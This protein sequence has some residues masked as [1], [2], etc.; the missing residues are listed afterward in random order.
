M[1]KESNYRLINIA[2]AGEQSTGRLS[3]MTRLSENK[4]V[5]PYDNDRKFMVAVRHTFKSEHF[6]INLHLFKRYDRFR[7]RIYSFSKFLRK[8]SAAIVIYDIT[9]RDSFLNIVKLI[10]ETKIDENPGSE[11][12][13]VYFILGNKSDLTKYREVSI[14]E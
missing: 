13:L 5:E 4:F 3:L 8:I 11:N 14:E 10:N 1:N 9:E 6:K 12:K 7:G 2:V